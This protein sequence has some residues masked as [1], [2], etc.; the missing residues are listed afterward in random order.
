MNNFMINSIVADK[1][2]TNLWYLHKTKTAKT[3]RFSL[4]NLSLLN[5]RITE[6]ELLWH[7]QILS[8]LEIILGIDSNNLSGSSDNSPLQADPTSIRIS[9]LALCKFSLVPPLKITWNRRPSTTQPCWEPGLPHFKQLRK[10]HR[11]SCS[12]KDVRP[13]QGKILKVCFVG[14]SSLKWWLSTGS[15]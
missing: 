6:I 8:H 5:A 15:V 12:M 2:K 1:N 14:S 10:A 7:L 4:W 11:L 3:P 13:F 9:T